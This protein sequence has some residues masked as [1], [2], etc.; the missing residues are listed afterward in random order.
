MILL[1]IP[2]VA[3]LEH[4]GRHLPAVPLVIGLCGN[5]LCNLLLFLVV[6][7][8]GTSVLGARVIALA[9]ARRGVVHAVEELNQLRVGDLCWVVDY[10]C[11]FGILTQKTCQPPPLF[12][13][14]SRIKA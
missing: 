11:C 10:L 5:F 2:P 7:E 9:I 8:Y 13:F 6:I 14:A 1:G 4:L 12:P 3:G